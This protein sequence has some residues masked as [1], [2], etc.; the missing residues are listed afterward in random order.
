MTR[1]LLVTDFQSGPDETPMDEW[2]P[3]EITAHLDYY[4]AL[5]AELTRSG[6]LVGGEILTGP[7]LAK[8]VR[9][10]G[11]AT[12]VTDGPFQE[13]KEWVAGYQIVE[14][15]SQERAL[16]IAALVSAVPGRDG[17]PTQQPIQVRQ[18]MDDSP[19]DAV[20]MAGYLD[21]ARGER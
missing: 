16:E 4:R 2:K 1:Y 5:T 12:V 20:E 8:V 15:E 10:D 3:E 6:E 14:V 9:S 11:A 17:V 7:D 21:T 19:L 18:V 13:F